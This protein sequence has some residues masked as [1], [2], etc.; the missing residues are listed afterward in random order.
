MHFTLHRRWSSWKIGFWVVLLVSGLAYA[1]SL[2]GVFIWDDHEIMSGSAIG[3]GKR[4]TDCFTR[5]FLHN[6]YRPL[7]SAS[8]FIERPLFRQT[9]LLYHQ[10]NILLHVLTTAAL[11]GLLSAAFRQKSIA[12]LG[13]LLFALQPVQVSAV[14]WIGGRTD[15]LCA[16]WMALFAWAL[17]SGVQA[18]GRTQ[19][20]LIGAALLAFTAAVF[21]KEQMLPA[22]LLVP[23][24]F[25]CWGK[26]EPGWQ[27]VAF[28][29]S[30]PF[31]LASL[32][33]VVLWLT[34]VPRPPSEIEDSLPY[35]LAQTLRTIVYYTLL[36]FAPT[37]QW[38]HT[39]SLGGF[40][41]AG[42]LP[43][44][45]GAVI[46]LAA[47]W[48]LLRWLRREPP[49]A[50]F[51]AFIL[52]TLLLVS[53]LYPV[54]SMVVTPYRAGVA[55]MGAAALLAWG[56]LRLGGPTLKRKA[57]SDETEPPS[58]TSSRSLRRLPAIRVAAVVGL[59]LW[60]GGLTL[61]GA[62]L[63]KNEEMA[64]R[65]FVRHDPDSIW[66]RYNLTSAL[67]SSR[68]YSEAIHHMETMLH[69]LFGSDAWRDSRN[70]VQTIETDHRLRARVHEIQGTKIGPGQWLSELY[71]RLGYACLE[72]GD[73][74]R[75]RTAFQ[76]GS[77]LSDRPAE[78]HAGL[79]ECAFKEGRMEEA[80]R[81]LSLTVAEDATADRARSMLGTAYAKMGRW[82]ESR[83]QFDILIRR[84]PWSNNAY[85]E[86][87]RAQI[88]L[89]DRQGAILTLET[90]QRHAPSHQTVQE[91]LKGLRA[92][93]AAL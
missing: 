67:I 91:M 60:W 11:M 35:I 65:V 23:L 79:G 71:A 12:L 16:L 4:F 58:E 82:K 45:A 34:I 76:V 69:R 89:G 55:G 80:A 13:G 56:V 29:N 70:V 26:R 44:V 28:L 20:V 21:T 90:A 30:I 52:T 77:R 18:E 48:L 1:R 3:G 74:S 22:F 92:S 51:L 24:A 64:A 25:W 93:S 39:M 75:A 40:V 42:W 62:G 19:K 32:A 84:L 88:K 8:F 68:K 87:A 10:S 54:P 27:R 37:P 41:R 49:A 43:I 83:D 57:P 17:V 66:A 38:M 72:T 6:Y 73:I 85:I 31:A 59:V 53:N 2:D 46:S 50:W 78:N 15:S 61:W 81:W 47:I 33:Y 5:P 63:W 36:L 86:K 7:V 14:A 9:P